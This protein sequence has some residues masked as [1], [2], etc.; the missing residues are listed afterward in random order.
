MQQFQ[1]LDQSDIDKSLHDLAA[2]VIKEQGVHFATYKEAESHIKDTA[3][4]LRELLQQSSVMFIEG[5]KH[6]SERTEYPAAD[7]ARRLLESQKNPQK[8]AKIIETHIVGDAQSLESFS[9]VVNSFY[10]CG[11]FHV[12]ECA[13]SVLL[14]LFPMEP[15]PFACYGTMVWRRDGIAAAE[16]FYKGI[17]DLFSNP[18]LDYFTADCYAK[19]G[20]KI[21][22][23]RLLQRALENGQAAPEIY[24]DIM[25]F[26]RIAL[27]EI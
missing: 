19:A 13:I 18:I 17:V 4:R 27:R 2:M 6:V 20:N 11:D 10:G 26:V 9:Q 3:E 14:T 16:N 7:V 21:E 5:L 25:Q 22:A 12:E 8:M 24:G 15:Q 1:S 23:K